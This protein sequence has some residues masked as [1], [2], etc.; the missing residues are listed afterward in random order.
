LNRLQA[1]RRAEDDRQ[2]A[3]EDVARA[4]E[5]ARQR[6]AAIERLRQLLALEKQKAQ[7]LPITPVPSSPPSPQLP[8]PPATVLPAPA[9]PPVL[10]PADPS[11]AGRY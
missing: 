5:R 3:S 8:A 4:A 2:Q 11:A 7:P 6:D 1:L 10:V 9:A